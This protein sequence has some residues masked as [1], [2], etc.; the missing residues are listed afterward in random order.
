M[1]LAEEFGFDLIL[2]GAAQAYKLKDELAAKGIPVIVAPL[3]HPFV[4]GEEIPDVGEYPAPDERNATWLR[5]A[6]VRVALGSFSRSFGALGPPTSGRW[7]LQQGAMAAGYGMT[8]AE[9]IK[10][11]T[12][13]AAEVL[14]IGDRVGSLT[15]GKDAD[16]VVLDGPPMSVKTWV[17]RTYVNG[18]LVY[19]RPRGQ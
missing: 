3:F 12:L 4:T 16:V 18:E 14:G 13:D 7:L 15:V 11:I 9:I 6:G 17:E 10:M 5:E 2:D 19:Q 1:R 8:E